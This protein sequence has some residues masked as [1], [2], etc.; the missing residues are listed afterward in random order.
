MAWAI[1][2]ELNSVFQGIIF[3]HTYRI[4]EVYMVLDFC[5]FSPV[6]LSYYRNEV[7]G[8]NLEEWRENYFSYPKRTFRKFVSYYLLKS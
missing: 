7:S 5:Y 3:P 8:K 6:N 2:G 4:Y 1:S